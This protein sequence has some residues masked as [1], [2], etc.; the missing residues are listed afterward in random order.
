M[1]RILRLLALLTAPV[2]FAQNSVCVPNDPCAPAAA[3]GSGISSAGTGASTA[4][5]DTIPVSDG[6]NWAAKAVPNCTDTGGNHL[7]YTA[8]TNAFSCGTTAS[9]GGGGAT[10]ALDNLVSVALNA[11]LLPGS[12]NTRALGS[13]TLPM[14]GVFMGTGG[15]TFEGSTADTNETNVVA[16]DPTADQTITWPNAT[17]RSVVVICSDA[18]DH[19]TTGTVEESLFACTIPAGTLIT[20]GTMLQFEAI[21][22]STTANSKTVLV[23]FGATTIATDTNAANSERFMLGQVNRVGATTQ[24]AH[25][26]IMRGTT[27]GTASFAAP[28]ETLSGAVVLD[29]RATTPTAAGEVILRTVTVTI[30]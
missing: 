17:G 27:F 9:G 4:A 19:A 11:D 24:K 21:Y 30:H 8:A 3:G 23:K 18:A 16:A 20:N 28:G 1:K 15:E 5:D 6:A 10:V 2:A 14:L 29:F 13:L 26:L 7:N 12:A 22:S 25:A